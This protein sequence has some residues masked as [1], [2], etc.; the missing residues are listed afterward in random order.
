MLVAILIVVA[1]VRRADEL[2]LNK[3]IWG[4][5]ALAAYFGTQLL[6]GLILGLFLVDQG[7][8]LEQSEELGLNLVGII[9]GG[10]CAYVAYQQMP[11]YVANMH[12]H[13]EINDLLDEDIFD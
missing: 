4:A 11:G 6:I 2:G 12:S 5:V 13:S 9:V 1:F 8:T 10:I 3:W 7:T